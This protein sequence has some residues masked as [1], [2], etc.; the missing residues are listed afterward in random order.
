MY[1]Y[2]FL[3]SLKLYLNN[4]SSIIGVIKQELIIDKIGYLINSSLTNSSF[5]GI[6]INL[7]II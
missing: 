3:I 2:L 5:K 1:K 6:D 4:S 7:L